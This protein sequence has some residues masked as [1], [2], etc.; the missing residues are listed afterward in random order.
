[1]FRGDYRPTDKD[2]IAVKYQTF[3]TR[4]VGINVDG[5]SARWGLVRQRYDFDVDIGKIDYTRILNTSTIL[6]FS[7][8]FFN[9]IE[10]GPPEDDV[11]LAGIQRA[12]YPQLERG[13]ASLPGSTIRSVSFRRRCSAISR[14]RT[15]RRATT[16]ARRGSRTTDAGRFTATTSR[17]TRQST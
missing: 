15:G 8:G 5:A 13:S 14:A 12:T 9:S 11:A 16:A 7:T 3:Y 4:S 2:S 6:E 17:S 1:M 10:N